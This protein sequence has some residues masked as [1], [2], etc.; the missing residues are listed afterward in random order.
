MSHDFGDVKVGHEKSWTFTLSNTAEAGQA[1]ITFASPP[2]FSVPVTKPQVFGFRT[3]ATNCLRQLMPQKTC[4]LTVQ[5]IPAMRGV[6][7]C[8][9]FVCAVTIKDNAANAD[10]T[11][12]LSGSGK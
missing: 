6:A 1:P 10:Q 11:I 8:E 7:Q 5:F 12:P 4:Q 9:P 2:A 3:G